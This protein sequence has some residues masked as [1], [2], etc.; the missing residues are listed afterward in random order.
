M[1]TSNTCN[2]TCYFQYMHICTGRI[3][4]EVWSWAI[5]MVSKHSF[6]HSNSIKERI[7]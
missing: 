5:P 7:Y 3:T 4:D 6:N 2:I 1:Y